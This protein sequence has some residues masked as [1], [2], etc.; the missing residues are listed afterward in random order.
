MQRTKLDT[1]VQSFNDIH[2]LRIQGHI[3]RWDEAI[4][5]GNGSLGCLLWG[6]GNPLRLSLDRSDLWDKRAAAIWD[7]PN[8]NYKEIIRLVKE[9]NADKINEMFTNPFFEPTPTKIP[10][11]RIEID[12][13]RSSSSMESHL[14]LSDAT[15]QIKL[16][17]ESTESEI[18]AFLHADCPFGFISIA[19]ELPQINLVPHHFSSNIE[20]IDSGKSIPSNSQS[21]LAYPI[22]EIGE[23]GNFNWIRQKT[24][25][26]LEFAVVSMTRKRGANRVD[27]VFTVVSSEDGDNWFEVTKLQL[28]TL[29][30]KGFQKEHIDHADWWFEFWEKSSICLPD[31]EFERQWYMANYL[32]G[33]CSRKGSVPM[34]LQGVW[35]ADQG[36]LPPWKGEYAND[37]NVQMSYWHALKANHLEEHESLTDFLWQLV[38]KAREFA[39]NFYDAPGLCFPGA[40]TVDAEPVGGYSMY[41]LTMASSAWLCQAFDH[42]W[43]YTGNRDF[44]RER[45]YPFLKESAEC[46]LRWLAPGEDGKLYLPVS[47]SPEIHDDSIDSWLTPNSN[48]DLSIM[49]YLFDRLRDMAEQLENGESDY[50]NERLGLLPQLAVDTNA[51]LMLS[52]D[53]IL[54][55]SHRHHSHTLAIY[56]F[57]MIDYTNSGSEKKIIDQS[58]S[59][60][61][62]LGTG[63]WNG[64]SFPWLSC[65]YARQGNGEGA[66]HQLRTF[67]DCFCS[68]NSFHLNGDYKNCGVSACHSND[69]TLEGNMGAAAAL[70]EMLLQSC[71]GTIRLFP[72]I[73]KSWRNCG[74]CFKH[75]RADGGVLVSA[76]IEDG[77]L[78]YVELES[79]YGGQVTVQN[80]FSTSELVVETEESRIII[81]CELGKVFTLD[82]E[83]EVVCLIH[84]V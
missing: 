11:G 6:N 39:E 3:E 81:T 37:L 36:L 44:L 55:H 49:I 59:H 14:S 83:P 8:T 58:I 79:Q 80:D 75:L 16:G 68:P 57:N 73:P 35:T 67:W 5:L 82:C 66:A 74:L 10:A 28:K 46:L 15:A 25:T 78:V 70:Q 77:S 60:L 1:N 50:W 7:E 26:D 20:D 53:E 62:V 63:Q 13:G 34:S 45:A 48:Y 32:L 30:N 19:G 42:Y 9:K 72:A 4:P 43:L 31:K 40:M 71:K 38:P 54:T 24:A 2:D 52:P 51:G 12:Y 65:L 27:V 17:F 47:S 76:A 22:A 69:F 18:T 33:S 64:Y 29:M 56:P 23:D 41:V 61:E 84:P 21:L